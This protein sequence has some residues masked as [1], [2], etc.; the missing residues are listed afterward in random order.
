MLTTATDADPQMVS[1]VKLDTDSKMKFV[2]VGASDGDP[3]LDFTK[4]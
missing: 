2:L 3:G 4:G 1:E